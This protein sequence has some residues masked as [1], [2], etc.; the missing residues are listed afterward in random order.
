MHRLAKPVKRTVLA[1]CLLCLTL[2]AGGHHP[3]YAQSEEDLVL[4]DRSAKAFSSV[5]KKA[6]PAVVHVG[7]EKESRQK[8]GPNSFRS[9]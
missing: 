2:L 1:S 9:V 3:S 7:V 8:H 5:V 6:G 4:L